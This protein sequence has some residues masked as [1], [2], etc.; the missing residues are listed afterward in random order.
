MGCTIVTSCEKVNTDH[1]QIYCNVDQNSDPVISESIVNFREKM[2]STNTLKSTEYIKFSDAVFLMEATFNFNYGFINK[3]YSQTEEDTILIPTNVN[4]NELIEISE[5]RNLYKTINH[6]ICSLFKAK[7]M[8]SKH[9]KYV[10]VEKDSL[11]L[12]TIIVIGSENTRKSGAWLNAEPFTNDL[13]PHNNG[14]WIIAN[15]LFNIRSA[16]TDYFYVYDEVATA[17]NNSIDLPLKGSHV[18]I[19]G[20]N[21]TGW[22]NEPVPDWGSYYISNPNIIGPNLNDPTDYERNRCFYAIEGGWY[23]WVECTYWKYDHYY[24]GDEPYMRF[25]SLNKMYNV[26]SLAIEKCKP[27]ASGYAPI[28]AVFATRIHEWYPQGSGLYHRLCEG[29]LNITYASKYK[30]PEPLA[31]LCPADPQE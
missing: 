6:E 25:S 21:K 29:V 31:A 18:Y 7:E 26:I 11:F 4:E 12:K 9:I 19:Y 24:E 14:K 22:L 5:V 16:T 2:I 30:Y 27:T 17:L 1:D 10:S 28:D 8:V 20:I 13:G 15:N 23:A 3:S